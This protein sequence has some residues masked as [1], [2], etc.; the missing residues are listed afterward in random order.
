MYIWTRVQPELAICKLVL[1]GFFAVIKIL[2]CHPCVL[3]QHFKN[4]SLPTSVYFQLL[5]SNYS[6]QPARRAAARDGGVGCQEA[7]HA[8]HAGPTFYRP[9]HK[10]LMYLVCLSEQ[11]LSLRWW[12]MCRRSARVPLPPLSPSQTYNIL[13]RSLF[14]DLHPHSQQ[15]WPSMVTTFTLFHPSHNLTLLKF[16]QAQ[17]VVIHPTNHFTYYTTEFL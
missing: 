14:T 4:T 12:T 13:P 2:I 7:G 15:A 5:L 16:T 11:T 6:I 9:S 1:R 8:N 17:Q 10:L 3:F